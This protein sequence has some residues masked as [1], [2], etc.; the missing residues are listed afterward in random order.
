M[1]SSGAPHPYQAIKLN[2]DL[3]CGTTLR[4]KLFHITQVMHAI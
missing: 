3:N 1:I 2:P 4:I